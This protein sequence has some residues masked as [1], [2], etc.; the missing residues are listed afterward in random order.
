MLTPL[1]DWPG[2]QHH[3]NQAHQNREHTT[4]ADSC[5]SYRD[6][7]QH[8]RH[9]RAIVVDLRMLVLHH[10]LEATLDLL[11]STAVYLLFRMARSTSQGN[12]LAILVSG[13]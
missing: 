2:A 8:T 3:G 4:G 12:I 5:P 1:P 13:L 6:T 7:A 11:P 9:P 10:C